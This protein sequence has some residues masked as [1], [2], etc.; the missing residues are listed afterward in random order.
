MDNMD[1]PVVIMEVITRVT[2]NPRRIRKRQ[3]GQTMQIYNNEVQTSDTQEY[4]DIA[5]VLDEIWTEFL[6]HLGS[7]TVLFLSIVAIVYAC[8]WFRYDPVDTASSTFVVSSGQTAERWE[9]LT[10]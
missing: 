7:I 2:I 10:T 6:R 3:V 8:L 5:K 9:E 4:I 1:I